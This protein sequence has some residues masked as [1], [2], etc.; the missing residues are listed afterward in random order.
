MSDVLSA[1]ERKDQSLHLAVN[2]L[3]DII[4]IV[5]SVEE[6]DELRVMPFDQRLGFEEKRDVI[7]ARQ[8]L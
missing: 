8:E 2:M 5:V 3:E 4:P 7:N 1:M 6:L